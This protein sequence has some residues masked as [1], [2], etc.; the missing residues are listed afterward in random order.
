MDPSMPPLAQSSE[1]S[2]EPRSPQAWPPSVQPPLVQSSPGPPVQS[3][4][5][6]RLAQQSAELQAHAHTPQPRSTESHRNPS[7]IA[8]LRSRG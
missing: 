5:L 7:S 3:S 8:Y 2:S 4:A 6:P 1:Q